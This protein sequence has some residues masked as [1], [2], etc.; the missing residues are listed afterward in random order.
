MVPLRCAISFPNRCAPRRLRLAFQSALPVQHTEPLYTLQSPTHIIIHLFPGHSWGIYQ[1]DG[2]GIIYQR[3]HH[4]H[5]ENPVTRKA[6]KNKKALITLLAQ[7][8]WM[9]LLLL[10]PRA[11]ASLILSAYKS[12]VR[13][14]WPPGP[15]LLSFLLA[16]AKNALETENG[17]QQAQVLRHKEHL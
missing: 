3:I 10:A 15:I 14:H 6:H 4:V 16:C 17:S 2:E 12:L 8:E 1:R 7:A 13:N 5:Q 9:E 11:E